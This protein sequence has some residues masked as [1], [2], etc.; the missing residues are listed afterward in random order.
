M[1]KM[2]ILLFVA[3]FGWACSDADQEKT[4]EHLLS[5]R[6]MA[7]V[8]IDAHLGE[9]GLLQIPRDRDS[10]Q[11][12]FARYM[13]QVYKRHKVDSTAFRESYAYYA[14]DPKK[15]DAI[16]LMVVD[17]L[18]SLEGKSGYTPEQMHQEP[19]SVKEMRL[20][21]KKEE[22]IKKEKE[23]EQEKREKKSGN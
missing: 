14:R 3:G 12:Y 23:I 19:D 6:E 11:A 22:R 4:P 2:L 21:Q 10:N 9:A 20:Q 17:S 18:S 15:I 8:L 13:E 1:R 5:E 16:Y 7:L